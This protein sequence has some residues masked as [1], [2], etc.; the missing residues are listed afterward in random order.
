MLARDGPVTCLGDT[1]PSK[2]CHIISD[3]SDPESTPA[4]VSPAQAEDSLHP[5]T[6]LAVRNP[7]SLVGPGVLDTHRDNGHNTESENTHSQNN[8]NSIK[9]S[10]KATVEDYT[11]LD[12]EDS[13]LPQPLS[14]KTPVHARPENLSKEQVN[15]FDS[16]REAMTPAEQNL[17]DKQNKFVQ[18]GVHFYEQLAPH[19]EGSS[20]GKGVDPQNWGAAGIP[21]EELDPD[22]QCK[23]F[24]QFKAFHVFNERAHHKRKLCEV[25]TTQPM[26]SIIDT[27]VLADKPSVDRNPTS[28]EDK[29]AELKARVKMINQLNKEVRQMKA[30]LSKSSKK[31]AK[32]ILCKKNVTRCRKPH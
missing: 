1:A 23:L 28:P 26:L 22:A 6:A 12:E 30:S 21:D 32:A 27:P 8:N 19:A 4:P 9:L 5:P 20:C 11:S 31:K 18:P 29:R 7:D 3:L 14:P 24:E 16:A 2:V 15:L 10:T 13:Q 17:V 25:E